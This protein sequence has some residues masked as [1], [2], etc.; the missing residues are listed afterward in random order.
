MI[1]VIIGTNRPDSNT[2]KVARA[3]REMIEQRS[4]E[5]VLVDLRELPAVLFD[6]TSYAAKPAEFAR[7][8]KTI[9][10]AEGILTVL[11]EYN[12][13]FPGVLKY[14]IDML[15]FPVSLKGM[16]SGFVGLAAGEWGGL[17]AVEQLE[18]IF[19]YRSAHLYGKRVFLKHIH[20]LLDAED[21]IADPKLRERL[22]GMVAGFVEFCDGVRRDPG[23]R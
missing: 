23:T 15:E 6:P 8:Q 22:E 18:M 20:N 9:L 12:G 13:S 14:F 5:A 1:A 16:P 10:E 7:F 11:P 4:R 2:S 3:L 17:R 19:Q 21:R